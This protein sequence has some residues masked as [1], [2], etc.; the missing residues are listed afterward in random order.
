MNLNGPE[1]IQGHGG[2]AVSHPTRDS[3]PLSLRTPL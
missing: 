1:F 2:A 3:L